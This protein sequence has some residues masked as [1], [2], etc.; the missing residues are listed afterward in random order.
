M[1]TRLTHACLKKCIPK[2]YREGELNKGEGV[3][4]DR[5]AAK[6]FDVQMKISEILQA[7]AQA[8]GAGGGAGGLGFGGM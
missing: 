5:C 8:K 3:C 4:I 2:D 6:F 7:E 1:G